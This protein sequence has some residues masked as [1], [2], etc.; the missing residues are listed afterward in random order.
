M[1]KVPFND[2]YRQHS[3]LEAEINNSIQ[4]AIKRSAFLRSS[5]VEAFESSFSQLVG[6]DHCI[7]CGNGTDSLYIAMRSLGVGEGDEVIVPAH[8]WI[9]TSETVSALGATAVFCD[10]NEF[11]LI[12]TE[13]LRRKITSRT[14]G[15]IP[16]HLFGQVADMKDIVSIAQEY[17]L[18]VLEDCAQAHLATQHGRAAGS[19]GIAASY[20]FYPGKNLGAMGDAGAITTNDLNLSKTFKRI[21]NHGSLFKG[22]HKLEGINSRMDGIQ[23]SILNVKLPHLVKW[24]DRRREVASA[25]S[26]ALTGVG[27]LILPR[28]APGNQHVWH[29]YV[30]R[31]SS[32]D[33]LKAFLAEKGIETVINYAI[34]LPFLDAYADR[35][36]KPRDFPMAFQFQN[37]ILSLPIF[38]EITNEEVDFTVAAIK[39]FFSGGRR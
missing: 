6:A 18:W 16:V 29:L 15:I 39:S 2:L 10:V 1:K 30:I 31:T 22:E 21:A 37:E 38:P 5:D 4:S 8:T 11:F 28:V 9:S 33:E 7:S 14:V 13:I 35:A 19:F 12:D 17:S 27:D 26:A 34:A 3:S 20:S 25:Y 36:H 32:R 23:A 24:T